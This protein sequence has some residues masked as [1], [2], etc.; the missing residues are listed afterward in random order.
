MNKPC[1]YCGKTD[2]P[3]HSGHVIPKSLYPKSPPGDVQR[4]TVPECESC[5]KIWTD[6]ETRFRN[7]LVIAGDPNPAVSEKWDTVT[8]SFGKPSGRKWLLDLSDTMIPVET[9]TGQRHM[10]YPYKD[11]CV[12]LVLRKIVRGLSAYHKLGDSIPDERVWVG[13]APDSLPQPIRTDM[14]VYSLGDD[15]VRYGYMLFDD[16]IDIRSGWLIRLYGSRDFIG[17]ISKSGDAK[18]KYGP[19]FNPPTC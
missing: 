10:V 11:P 5:R 13:Y 19:L 8:R 3:R 16:E 7:I 17:M 1:A 9:E 18:G 12:N 2:T 14:L 6:A 4:P 15:F